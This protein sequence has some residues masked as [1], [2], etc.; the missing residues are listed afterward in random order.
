MLN[1]LV[2]ELG[3]LGIF[4][5]SIYTLLWSLLSLYCF[6]IIITGLYSIMCYSCY[7]FCFLFFVA[8][9]Y[10]GINL[11]HFT[12]VAYLLASSYKTLVRICVSHLYMDLALQSFAIAAGCR[13]HKVC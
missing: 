12:T 8:F 9:F 5:I 11:H 6:V 10:W 2:G 13:Y 7:Y 4:C 1:W 3:D